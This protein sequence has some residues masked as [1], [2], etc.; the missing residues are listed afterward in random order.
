MKHRFIKAIALAAAC[1]ALISAAGCRDNKKMEIPDPT[2]GT[3]FSE[4]KTDDPASKK[5]KPAGM[6]T[7]VDIRSARELSLRG[8]PITLDL[9]SLNGGDG[10]FLFICRENT[11]IVPGFYASDPASQDPA[12]T[13]VPI[14]GKGSSPDATDKSGRGFSPL[15]G[16]GWNFFVFEKKYDGADVYE[17][18][19]G[20]PLKLSEG[21]AITVKAGQYLLIMR[22]MGKGVDDNVNPF[23]VLKGKDE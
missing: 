4:L 8:L 9:A 13:S 21:E 14:P 18:E 22:T 11:E 23:I 17:R 2:E 5:V 12:E 10:Y 16:L 20:M 3:G 6:K 19:I 1:I 15:F 7:S